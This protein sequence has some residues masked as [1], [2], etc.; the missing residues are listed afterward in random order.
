MLRIITLF[1][2]NDTFY[3]IRLYLLNPDCTSELYFLI[4]KIAQY[5]VFNDYFILFFQEYLLLLW[6][7]RARN[8]HQRKR[9]E[10]KKIIWEFESYRRKKNFWTI[11]CQKTTL[12]FTNSEEHANR[13]SSFGQHLYLSFTDNKFILVMLACQNR[14]SYVKRWLSYFDINKNKSGSMK[15]VISN[16]V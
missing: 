4:H 1:L 16:H 7:S 6:W 14:K 5:L 11:F 12:A 3:V 8:Q 2:T 10:K 9:A 15:C 13:E